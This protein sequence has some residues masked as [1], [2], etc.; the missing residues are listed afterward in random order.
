MIFRRRTE[1]A[2][3][4]QPERAAGYGLLASAVVALAPHVP[5]WPWWLTAA[6]GLLFG[7][8]FLML[9]RGWPAASSSSTRR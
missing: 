3:P 6:L 8:R 7:W 5:R 9:R 4:E 2:A 1:P